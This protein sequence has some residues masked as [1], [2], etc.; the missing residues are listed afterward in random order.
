[1]TGIWQDSDHRPVTPAEADQE[2]TLRAHEVLVEVA[3]RWNR[4]IAYA[5][6]AAEVQRRT[7]IHTDMAIE[8]WLDDV[9]TEINSRCVEAGK[10]KLVAL[11]DLPNTQRDDSAARIACY[12]AYGAR[13]P[14]EKTA[15][16]RAGGRTRGET[17]P[18]KAPTRRTAKPEERVRPMCP[19]C[20]V[21]LPATGICDTCD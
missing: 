1:M 6:L 8:D 9:L 4:S 15:P 12:E 14:R 13:K 19:T 21:E 20:F 11:V 10:P 5:D 7:G 18:K 3:G 16:V 2:W 17:R